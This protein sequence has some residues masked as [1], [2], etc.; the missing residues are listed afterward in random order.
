VQ[1]GGQV[2]FPCVGVMGNDRPFEGTRHDVEAV[3]YSGFLTSVWRSPDRNC[4]PWLNLALTLPSPGA[5][6]A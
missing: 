6:F 3:I 5:G 4:C 1:G 2:R